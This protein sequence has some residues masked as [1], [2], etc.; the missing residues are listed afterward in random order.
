VLELSNY[1]IAA[2][3]FNENFGRQQAVTKA[4]KKII[5]F[6]FPKAKQGEC[7]M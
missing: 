2:M 7:K 3:H 1:L 6:Y 5:K 4:G